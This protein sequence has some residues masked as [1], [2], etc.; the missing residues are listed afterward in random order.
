MRKV[1][2]ADNGCT[3]TGRSLITDDR[4]S[5]DEVKTNKMDNKFHGNGLR[6]PDTLKKQQ[7]NLGAG[8]T[9]RD[10]G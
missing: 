3:V 10:A 5:A 2:L 8:V 4:Q 7:I 6:L 1:S 9:L